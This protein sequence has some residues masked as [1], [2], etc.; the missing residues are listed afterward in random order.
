MIEKFASIQRMKDLMKRHNLKYVY[1]KQDIHT[2]HPGFDKPNSDNRPY[3]ISEVHYDAKDDSLQFWQ[4]WSDYHVGNY[5]QNFEE[6]KVFL[7]ESALNETLGSLKKYEVKVTASV[8]IMATSSENAI[9]TVQHMSS[10]DINEAMYWI[11]PTGEVK[12]S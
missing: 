2:T 9:A 7:V 3:T 5:A 6:Q 1:L 11:I 10:P 4:H 8:F 12:E